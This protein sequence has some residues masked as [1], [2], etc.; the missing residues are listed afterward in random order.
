MLKTMTKITT[1][2]RRF[3]PLLRL[4]YDALCRKGG[5]RSA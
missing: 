1:G 3:A 5:R 4:A 2:K